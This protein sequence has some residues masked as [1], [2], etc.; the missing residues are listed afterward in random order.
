MS[1]R[2]DPLLD[3]RM[4]VH[5]DQCSPEVQKMIRQRRMPKGTVK[6]EKEIDFAFDPMKYV[7]YG[8]PSDQD[9]VF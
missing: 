5:F 1:E 6:V 8:N 4:P 7:K 2:V 3:F 9:N